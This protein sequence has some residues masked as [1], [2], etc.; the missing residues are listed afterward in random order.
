MSGLIPKFRN[1]IFATSLVIFIT[2]RWH[3]PAFALQDVTKTGATTT[4]PRRQ[5]AVRYQRDAGLDRNST[6]LK[7]FIQNDLQRLSANRAIVPDPESTKQINTWLTTATELAADGRDVWVELSPDQPGEK[8]EAAETSMQLLDAASA[9]LLERR[10]LKRIQALATLRTQQAR[11]VISGFFLPLVPARTLPGGWDAGL[12]ESIF[13]NFLEET[14]LEKDW[15]ARLTTQDERRAFVRSAG[16]VP[17]LAWRCRKVA[18]FYSRLA[19]QTQ[20]LTGRTL[21]V[22]S[23]VAGGDVARALFAE[24][25]RSGSSPVVAWRWMAF[26]PSLWKPVS[27]LE[28]IGSELIEPR[29]GNQEL[30]AHPDVELAF[31]DWGSRGQWFTAQ[32]LKP[33]SHE[34]LK[35]AKSIGS[36]S[37]ESVIVASLARRDIAW[38]IVD[39]ETTEGQA[40]GLADLINRY[41]A[42]PPVDT[43]SAGT[44]TQL[45]GLSIRSHLLNKSTVIAFYNPLPCRMDVNMA[46][47]STVPASVVVKRDGELEWPGGKNSATFDEIALSIAPKSWGRIELALPNADSIGFQVKLPEEAR[48]VV[49]TRYED[50]L[51]HRTGGAKPLAGGVVSVG[52][53]GEKTRGRRLMAALQAYRESRLAD[54]FRLSDGILPERRTGRGVE[55]TARGFQDD[56]SDRP[57]IR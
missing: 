14:G 38:M 29:P 30:A 12:N 8:S 18:D 17:W 50:L 1:W 55:S 10:Y 9:N 16:L 39:H 35:T 31:S 27:G 11:P 48:E 45:Q 51:G 5:V 32:P 47:A 54:F 26:D 20:A 53:M 41:Q 3:S 25:E 52:H 33:V 36:P 19:D 22:A 24:A 7:T 28:L 37:V 34:V 44:S 4:Q 23:P 57:K 6:D 13:R 40:A 46:F 42:L 15:A 56:L 21:C 43:S 49:Q 2:G